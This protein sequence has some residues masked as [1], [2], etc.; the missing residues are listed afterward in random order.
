[1]FN[2]KILHRD[3]KIPVLTEEQLKE[4]ADHWQ[5]LFEKFSIEETEEDGIDPEDWAEEEPAFNAFVFDAEKEADED[6][7]VEGAELIATPQNALALL[8]E[9]Q[10]QQLVSQFEPGFVDSMVELFKKE[11]NKAEKLN[12]PYWHGF[13]YERLVEEKKV[14]N[15]TFKTPSLF[16]ESRSVRKLRDHSVATSHGSDFSFTRPTSQ[17]R[18]RRSRSAESSKRPQPELNKFSFSLPN[19]IQ[20]LVGR[21]TGTIKMTVH[22]R[23]FDIHVQQED[24]SGIVPLV[25]EAAKAMPAKSHEKKKKTRRP[26]KDDLSDDSDSDFEFF[27]PQM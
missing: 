27:V 9:Q 19:S 4:R 8:P 1:M 2:L 6:L 25:F 13:H 26:T 21:G 5:K 20:K 16:R 11:E 15:E 24:I 22:E 7:I 3:V 14:V 18:S 12:L 17:P 23:T 10:Y